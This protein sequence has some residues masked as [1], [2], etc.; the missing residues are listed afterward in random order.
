MYHLINIF[1]NHRMAFSNKKGAC[2]LRCT[3]CNVI[4]RAKPGP[5]KVICTQKE[6][7]EYSKLI[8]KKVVFGNQ[9]C[10]VSRCQIRK[11]KS[12]INPKESDQ[13]DLANLKVEAEESEKRAVP[14]TQQS[15]GSTESS[16]CGGGDSQ[17]SGNDPSYTT[18]IKPEQA[19]GDMIEMPINR[20]VSTHSY[21]CIC[22]K[23]DIK[24]RV[25]PLEAR[26]QVYMKKRIF[27]PKENRCCTEHLI[28]NRF[29][30]NEI[31]NISIF[32]NTLK[33][34][35]SELVQFLGEMS[36][37][38][39]TTLHQQIGNF[40]LSEERIK[41]FTGLYFCIITLLYNQ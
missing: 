37:R 17:S 21:C 14:D 29:Y 8:N 3:K 19:D 15:T 6:A 35:K 36:N 27:I 28:K 40:A 32:S 11:T 33:I 31:Q 7:D 12:D 4:L 26:L 1:F 9:F 13:F 22:F 2:D 30:D 5:R 24:S 16:E 23:S 38:C 25:I 39:E 41:S 18:R 34:E 20:T 10:S